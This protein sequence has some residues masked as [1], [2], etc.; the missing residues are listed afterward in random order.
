VLPGYNDLGTTRPDIAAEWHPAKNGTL[1]PADVTS[2]SSK[3]IW[4]ICAKGHEWKSSIANRSNGNGCPVCA[5]ERRK[6]KKISRMKQIE[7]ENNG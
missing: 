7:E 5:A 6:K 2:G 3:K 1:T 4:W